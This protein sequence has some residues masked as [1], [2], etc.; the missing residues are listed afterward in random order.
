MEERYQAR[1]PSHRDRGSHRS[2]DFR[3]HG[4]D[5][6]SNQRER[7]PASPIP[8]STCSRRL[9]E[10]PIYERR[11]SHRSEDRRYG[12]DDYR[13]DPSPRVS[14]R[15]L[16]PPPV[17]RRYVDDIPPEREFEYWERHS[18]RSSSRSSLHGGRRESSKYD[19]EPYRGR[20]PASPSPYRDLW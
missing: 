18:E 4:P 17:K 12:R 6:V 5:Q 8:S 9:D 13:P 10:P 15:N 20:K 11:R 1:P 19:V 14:Y 7:K 16:S 3:E 2:R